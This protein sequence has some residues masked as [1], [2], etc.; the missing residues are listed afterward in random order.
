VQFPPYS[1][2]LYIDGEGTFLRYTK[3]L[4][5]MDDS[6][7][8]MQIVTIGS[9]DKVRVY[10]SYLYYIN[11]IDGIEIFSFKNRCILI[12]RP[13]INSRK[14]LYVDDFFLLELLVDE[15]VEDELIKEVLVERGEVVL[16]IIA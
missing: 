2:V 10:D 12:F 6:D 7:D 14:E 1:I 4:T 8:E 9:A 11:L 3:G 15:K 5:I 13:R 16:S